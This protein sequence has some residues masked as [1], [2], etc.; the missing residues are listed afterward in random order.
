M[1]MTALIADLRVAARSLRNAPGFSATAILIL[2]VA[3]AAVTTILSV[4]DQLV[5]NPVTLPDPQSLVAIWFNNPQRNV[6]SPSS[7]LPRY[8]EM[9]TRATSFSS[10]GAAAGD[11]MTLTG[12]GDPLQVSVLRVSDTFLPTLGVLPAKGRNFAAAEDVANGPAVCILS[13]EFWQAQFGGRDDLVGGTIQ[14]DGR[15]WQVIGIMPPLLTAPFTQVQI[16]VPRVGDVTY[17]TSQQV[18]NG[19]T[20]FQPIARLKRGVSIAQASSELN[21]LSA[22]YKQQYPAR[23]DANNVSYARSFVEALVSGLAPSVQAL[24]GAV[25]CVLL[26]ACANTAALFLNRLLSRRKDIAVRLSLGASR[27]VIVRQFLVE[28]LVF[29]AAAALLGTLIAKWSLT[30]VTS[31][32]STQL[33]PNT[34]VLLNWRVLGAMIVVALGT[35]VAIGVLPALQASRAGVVEHLKDGARGTSAGQGTRLRHALVVTEVTLSIVLLIGSALLLVSF[36]KL[37]RSALGFQT[38]GIG[39]AFVGLAPSRYPTVAQQADFYDAVVERLRADPAITAASAALGLPLAGATRMPY[40]VGGRPVP[41]LGERPVT[42][43]NVVGPEFFKVFDIPIAEGRGFTSD[44]RANA[45]FVGMVNQALARRLFSDGRAIGETILLG[46][47]ADVSV[48]IVG[49]IRDVKSAGANAPVPDELYLPMR[50]RTNPSLSI[51][52]RTTGDPATL[53]SAIRR[54]VA[55]VDPNQA[56]SFFSTM[57][58]I[59][60]QALGTQ[61]IV[62]TLASTFAALA[63]ALALIG[64]YS[65]IAYSVS[66][67]T[68]ELGIRIALG[69]SAREVVQLV[70]RGGMRVI[71]AGV[72]AGLVG[73]ALMG[74]VIRQLLFGIDPLDASVYAAVAVVFLLVAAVACLA[75]SLRASRI[76]PLRALRMD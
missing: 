55:A 3:L 9:L 22:A 44:D 13:H 16:F 10:I 69:A 20:Y 66:Q 56:I 14:L 59:A 8:R 75:P 15:A 17:L 28:A 11:T 52:A 47:D 39:T 58:T 40:A 35:A 34:A 30:L 37:Q 23:L 27:A 71:G 32:L 72:A 33:P 61:Q 42:T 45:P 5:L 57:D 26:I 31:L 62:A 19:A 63:A 74:R 21:T 65:V 41:P 54:A 64:V 43:A 24:V 6:Q 53:Q 38:K 25:F 29:S 50:Q 60:A 76:D 70:M 12:N 48:R 18:D 2:A 7:S 67:R 4:F 68:A 49:I 46:R 51:V 73:A 36:V 1:T